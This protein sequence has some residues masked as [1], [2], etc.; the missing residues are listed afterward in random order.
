MLEVVV[1]VHLDYH[2]CFAIRERLGGAQKL[3]QDALVR[4]PLPIAV[5]RLVVHAARQDTVCTDPM[6]L[7]VG[8]VE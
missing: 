1:Y 3:P 4:F 5:Q 2:V 8:L 7:R 6:D